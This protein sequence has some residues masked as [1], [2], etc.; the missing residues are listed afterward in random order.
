MKLYQ[1]NSCFLEITGPDRYSFLNALITQSI[2]L[3]EAPFPSI[4]YTALLYPDGRYFLDFFMIREPERI[5][6]EIEQEEDLDELLAFFKKYK[7]RSKV[8]FGRLYKPKT[9]LGY[10]MPVH[11]KP[12]L[13]YSDLRLADYIYRIYDFERDLEDIQIAPYKDYEIYRI[14]RGVPSRNDLIRQKSI[15]LE[16]GF[17]EFGAINWSKGCY[18]GQELTARTRYRGVVRKRLWPI[19]F[20]NGKETVSTGD[21]ITYNNKEVGEL[22]T[23]SGEVGLAMLRLEIFNGSFENVE[24]F[25]TLQCGEAELNPLEKPHWFNLSFTNLEE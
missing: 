6:L 17:F 16:N 7:L 8:E 22:R 23:F 4:S 5:I 25:P 12:L 11:S 20:I 21:K 18:L 1:L 13:I 9:Y 2:S 24:D 10:K 19:K 3:N 14:M 15:I